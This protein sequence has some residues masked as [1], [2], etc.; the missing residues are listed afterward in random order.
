MKLKELWS[1]LKRATKGKEKTDRLIEKED[2]YATIKHKTQ[3]RYLGVRALGQHNNRK[4]TRG[5]HIQYVHVGDTSK[6]IYHGAK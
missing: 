1:W 3:K 2:P 4:A 6:P 5:R